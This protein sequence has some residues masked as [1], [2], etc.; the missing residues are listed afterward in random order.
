MRSR[1]FG[2]L[3]SPSSVSL[4]SRLPAMAAHAELPSDSPS[5]GGAARSRTSASRATSSSHGQRG[6]VPP[7]SVQEQHSFLDCARD[8]NFS[9]V[10]SLVLANPG[11]VNCQ[12]AGR[13]S[14][15]HQ[16]A[17][18]GDVTTVGFLLAHG[19]NANAWTMDGRSVMDLAA[20]NVRS[21]IAERASLE[22]P[23][24]AVDANGKTPPAVTCASEEAIA[25]LPL[26]R[27][28]GRCS[29]GA[30]QDSE[31]GICLEEFVK[32]DKF[33]V[34]PCSHVFHAKCV[35]VW[36]REKSG[37]CPACRHRIA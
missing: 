12:P 22:P 36:L 29:A 1:N 16:A 19:A 14:A 7:P 27:S 32:G 4:A 34:L 30:G 33:R 17:R 20:P 23:P 13:W 21:R 24:W 31:C 6:G 28:A 11:L 8:Y 10:R 25:A 26:R 3:S 37:S 5:R 15:L 2:G 9:H 18:K 35:D